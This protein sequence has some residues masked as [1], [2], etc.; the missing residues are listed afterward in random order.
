MSSRLLRLKRRRS[1]VLSY[2]KRGERMG[3]AIP[4]SAIL[5]LTDLDL[6]IEKLKLDSRI[7]TIRVMDVDITM[8]TT[9]YKET[10]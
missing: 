10:T 8:R 5:E 4:P 1:R 7:E 6:E 3:C 9:T 2:I